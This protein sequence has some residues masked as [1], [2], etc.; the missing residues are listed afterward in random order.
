MNGIRRAVS[1]SVCVLAVTACQPSSADAALIVGG[2][3]AMAR[4]ARFQLA[5]ADSSA[6][7]GA[8]PIAEWRLPHAL[9]EISGLALTPDGRLLAHDDELGAI[10]EVDYRRGVIVKRFELGAGVVKADFEGLT[11]VK[12]ALYLLAANGKLYEFHEG[13]NGARVKYTVHDTKLTKECEFEGI[14]FDPAINALLLAC[15]NVH[16]KGLR[17]QLVIYRWSLSDTTDARVTRLTVPLAGIIGPNGWKTLNPTDITVDPLTGNYIL[18]AALEKAILSITPD[19]A[20]VFARPLP[21]AH[22]QAEGVAITK[23]GALIVSDEARVRPAN[24]TLYRWQ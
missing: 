11:V 4:E 18:I 15:K 1:A 2:P 7:L 12:D 13:A 3:T 14:A 17:D 8:E 24:I 6:D 22:D 9:Q 21:A 23:D 16:T 5:L 20:V 10:W 19:G